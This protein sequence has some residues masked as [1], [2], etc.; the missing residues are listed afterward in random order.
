MR[1]VWRALGFLKAHRRSVFTAYAAWIVANLLDLTIPLQVRDAIDLG[2]RGNDPDRLGIAVA[3][4]L[5]L[6]VGK[7][8]INW[9][10]TWSFHAFEAD[11]ARDLR[12][13]V[14]RGL[15]RLSFAYLDRADTGQLIARATDRKS[16]RLNSSHEWISRMPSSA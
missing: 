8:A 3:S 14:Y 1:D 6:Y 16:T 13:A 15:Q 4:A 9:I 7:S 10:Y 2:I 5:A 11:A 12:N